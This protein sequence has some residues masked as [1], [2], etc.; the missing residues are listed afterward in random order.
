MKRKGV[1]HS[2]APIH[3]QVIRSIITH[4]R[5]IKEEALFASKLRWDASSSEVKSREPFGY[6][7]FF[8]GT[9]RIKS[10]SRLL[11]EEGIA[12]IGC[13]YNPPI[14]WFP[15]ESYQKDYQI[16][17]KR[18]DASFGELKR[19]NGFISLGEPTF[20]SYNITSLHVKSQI[21]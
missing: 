18:E 1:I 6:R 13:R 19:S 17:K 21:A 4:F 8:A 3:L 5:E 20:P 15:P 16:N 10:Y 2:L 12:W 11:Q 7:N 9:F 14:I